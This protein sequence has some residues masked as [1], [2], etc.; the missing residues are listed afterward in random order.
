MA[1]IHS[2]IFSGTSF[3]Y[4]RYPGGGHSYIVEDMDVR[5]GLSNPC[6]CINTLALPYTTSNEKGSLV[7]VIYLNLFKD[8]FWWLDLGVSTARRA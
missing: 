8:H 5:Q 4:S 1:M 7:Y 2:S 6:L 3:Y